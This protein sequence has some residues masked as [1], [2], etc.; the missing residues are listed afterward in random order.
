MS[1]AAISS[2]R[3]LIMIPDQA[4]DQSIPG[5]SAAGDPTRR[6]RAKLAHETLN[7]TVSALL[8]AHPRAQR[9]VL[10]SELLVALPASSSRSVVPASGPALRVVDADTLAAVA[11]LPNPSA[12]RDRVAVLGMASP[13]RP[14]GGVL[15]G[16]TSQ[17]E[18]LCLRSTLH[19]S[20]CDE[21]YGLPDEG[22]VYSPDVPVFRAQDLADTLKKADRWFVDIISCAAVRCPEPLA[23][24]ETYADPRDRDGMRARMMQVMRCA[25][26]KGVKKIVLGA[27]GCG[28]YGNP[29]E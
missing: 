20:L 2:V 26:A 13:L 15:A 21:W 5:T 25:R 16:A 22:V 6:E 11:E 3:D 29:P 19:A 24:G 12:Q 18:S 1:S 8:R 27:L 10:A 14:G 4:M 7:K 28:A 23:D 9:G 17:E